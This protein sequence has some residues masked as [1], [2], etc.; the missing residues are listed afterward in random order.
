MTTRVQRIAPDTTCDDATV[1]NAYIN[2]TQVDSWSFNTGDTIDFTIDWTIYSP[3]WSE[4]DTLKVYIGE[5]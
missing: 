2:T 4:N 1:V 3:T 5:G